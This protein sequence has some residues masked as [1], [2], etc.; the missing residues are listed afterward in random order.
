MRC[1]SD[2]RPVGQNK[3]RFVTKAFDATED[4]IPA[5]SVQPRRMRTQF[6]K[7]L[8]HFKSRQDRLD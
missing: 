7:D 1:H 4:I 5:S 3:L 2:Q 6:V 8:I